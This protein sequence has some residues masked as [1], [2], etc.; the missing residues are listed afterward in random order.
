MN[1]D[2]PLRISTKI[3]RISPQR[4]VSRDETRTEAAV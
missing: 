3:E 1:D 2:G 4:N